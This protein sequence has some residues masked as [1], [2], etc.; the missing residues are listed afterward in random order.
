MTEGIGKNLVCTTYANNP[1]VINLQ[2][3]DWSGFGRWIS[4]LLGW[5][6]LLWLVTNI[7]LWDFLE[8]VVSDICYFPVAIFLLWLIIG[9]L[10]VFCATDKVFVVDNFFSRS[11]ALSQIKLRSVYRSAVAQIANEQKYWS[12][13]SV[14]PDQ[15]C[16]HHCWTVFFRQT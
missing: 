10:R 6:F 7:S 16:L 13:R 12:V 5:H 14:S 1:I 8:N 4:F 11:F 2:E 9:W 3:G 15:F